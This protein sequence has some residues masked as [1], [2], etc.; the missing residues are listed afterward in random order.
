MFSA[1]IPLTAVENGFRLGAL[2][3]F[4]CSMKKIFYNGHVKKLVFIGIICYDI[5]LYNKLLLYYFLFLFLTL[6]INIIRK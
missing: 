2:I 4:K 5:F 1:T 6:N 3:T